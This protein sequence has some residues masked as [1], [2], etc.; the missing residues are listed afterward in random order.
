MKIL[1]VSHEFPPIG[2]GGANACFFLTREF[3]KQGHEVTVLTAKYMDQ[4]EEEITDE[5][6]RIYRVKCLRKNK[7]KSNF[8]EMFTFLFNAWFKAEKLQAENKYDIC[9]TF[10]GIPSGPIALH[11]KNK[12]GLPYIVRFGGGDIPGAQKR[13]KYVYKVLAPTI[14]K[15]W[16]EA[17]GLIANSEG[18]KLRAQNFDDNYTIDVIE[19][20]VDNQFFI[21]DSEKTETDTI[22]ILFVSRLIEGKGLQYLIPQ[23]EL[24]AHNVFERCSKKVQL[25]IVG[26]GPY[27]KQLE[28]ITADTHAE[29]YVSFE[30]RKNKEEV[31]NYYREA[32]IFVLPSLSEGMPNVV[33][34]A[35]ASGLP[36]VMTPCEGSKELVE[37]NGIISSL[38]ELSDNIT[39]LC[40]DENLRKTMGLESVKRV[41]QRFQW[42]S[43]A[44][45]YLLLLREKA[46]K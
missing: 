3:V 11:L 8:P 28:E 33:L 40:I 2:G 4:A 24:I 35:M 42:E 1:V 14:R 30:G 34:E 31:R 44:R 26:D 22:K 16:R 10:F 15:I 25:V 39:K 23:M 29:Q 17:G 13:F 5:Q 43:I 18:L 38:E 12:Y 6:V 45:R 7:E 32:N 37:G 21:P 19:N 36:I 46:R 9:L 27:R 20:G 41:K